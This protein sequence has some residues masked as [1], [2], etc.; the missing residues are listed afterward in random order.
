MTL[1][2]HVVLLFCTIS[3]ALAGENQP[4]TLDNGTATLVFPAKASGTWRE[5]YGYSGGVAL[6]N[7]GNTSP[8][9]FEGEI[10]FY[11]SYCP[12]RIPFVAT[13]QPD[14]VL[15][16]V[17]PGCGNTVLKLKNKGSRWEGDASW[18]ND[19]SH[20]TVSLK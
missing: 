2:R 13:L 18:Q 12:E 3:L 9:A 5:S 11:D 7:I 6:D 10:I 17:S 19:T 4:A 8:K 16:L 15:E 14:G 1:I 20:G